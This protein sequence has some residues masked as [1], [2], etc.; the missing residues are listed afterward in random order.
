[1][2]EG[3]GGFP[4]ERCV[5][6]T[7]IMEAADVVQAG[8]LEPTSGLP[9]PTPEQCGLQQSENA[10]DGRIIAAIAFSAHRRLQSMF[11]QKLLVYMSTI[12]AAT[13]RR[14]NTPS[15]RL[16]VHQTH[17]VLSGCVLSA[18]HPRTDPARHKRIRFIRA[19]PS[20]GLLVWHTKTSR[21]VASPRPPDL[22]CQFFLAKIPPRR[23]RCCLACPGPSPRTQPQPSRSPCSTATTTSFAWL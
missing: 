14:M 7:G 2:F 20:A 22:S 11:A 1:M 17:S 21:A 18:G 16:H 8:N 3:H 13:V 10:F 23:R 15:G 19:A 5:S 4:A 12:L 9:V 6:A